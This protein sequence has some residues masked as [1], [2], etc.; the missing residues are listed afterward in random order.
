MR[1]NLFISIVIAIYVSEDV[2]L[3]NFEFVDNQWLTCINTLSIVKGACS[4]KFDYKNKSYSFISAHLTPNDDGVEKRIEE[5][6]EI[7]ETNGMNRNGV[8][9][10]SK[11]IIEHDYVIW[12]GDLNFR[13]DLSRNEVI[14]LVGNC[15]LQALLSEDQLIKSIAK[16]GILPG[17]QE[18]PIKF[19]PT[20]KYNIGTDIF[21][22]EKMRTPS[23]TDRILYKGYR[24]ILYKRGE[25][26]IS[27]HR[28]V[29][30]LLT[31]IN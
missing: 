16:Y 5:I 24:S 12:L 3:N 9:H 17:L 4:I 8:N 19:P 15:N 29:Y 7:T 30:S 14:E 25:V 13:I 6:R 28:P 31:F 27:D 1:S 21:D 2:E 20:Y 22:N 26:K 11:S 18:A 23:Y 10:G